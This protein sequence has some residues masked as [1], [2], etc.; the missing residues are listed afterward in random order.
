MSPTGNGG[1]QHHTTRSAVILSHEAYKL[2]GDADEVPRSDQGRP[3]PLAAEKVLFSAGSS[4]GGRQRRAGAHHPHRSRPS[5]IRCSARRTR[6]SAPRR[7][8]CTSA[9]DMAQLLALPGPSTSHFQLTESTIRRP[10]ASDERSLFDGMDT[11][12]AGLRS[13]PAP[14]RPGPDDGPRRDRFIGAGGAEKVRH[15]RR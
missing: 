10:D 12:I 11:S 9:R 13:L 6:R 15:R 1:G 2:A 5:T 14:V 4:S 3:A 7:A 8:A